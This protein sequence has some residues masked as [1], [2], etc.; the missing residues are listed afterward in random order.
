MPRVTPAALDR[1]FFEQPLLQV[2]RRLL[3]CSLVL[4]H[5]GTLLAGR[6]VETEAYAGMLDPASH[7]FRG[8]T[9]RCRT[10]FGRRGHAYVYFTYGNHFCMNVTAGTDG[11]ASAILLRAVEPTAGRT[12]MRR[13]RSDS[14]SSPHRARDLA[15]GRCDHEMSNGP[16]KLAAAFGID[17]RFDG[18]DLTSGTRLWIAPGVRARKVLWTPRIGLGNSAAAA[19]LWRCVDAEST[20]T[21]KTPR[22]WPVA[23]RPAPSLASLARRTPR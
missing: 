18:W 9:D 6:I 2:A 20:G 22:A 7:S 17:R 3:G 16:G 13:L 23:A 8:P 4:V 10:M 12:T 15:A 19:H 11:L 1:R 5:R 14:T 21:T